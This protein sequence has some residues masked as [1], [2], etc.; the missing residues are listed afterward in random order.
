MMN[1]QMRI[2][3]EDYEKRGI[4]DSRDVDYL[5]HLQIPVPDA[6]DDIAM[7]GIARAILHGAASNYTDAYREIK[8]WF[9]GIASKRKY[10]D[11]VC[12]DLIDWCKDKDLD[13]PNL[14]L[15]M[16]SFLTWFKTSESLNWRFY[17]LLDDATW[18]QIERDLKA[19][20]I[21]ALETM[22][23]IDLTRRREVTRHLDS[24]RDIKGLI[25]CVETYKQRSDKFFELVLKRNRKIKGFPFQVILLGC[26]DLRRTVKCI[27]N[28]A[29]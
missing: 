2:A 21:S 4:M 12:A 19:D 15:D 28:M 29:I 1:K 8:G 13:H 17:F 18:S 9:L 20:N 7:E 26:N 24:I 25:K 6:T 22:Y 5:Q 27:V 10:I 3:L 23:D 16:G 14:D 11:E